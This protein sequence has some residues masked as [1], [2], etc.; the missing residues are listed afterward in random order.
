MG[1]ARSRPRFLAEIVRSCEQV[2]VGDPARP[3]SRARAAGANAFKLD[4]FAEPSAAEG[5][6]VLARERARCSRA[7]KSSS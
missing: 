3:A 4:R 7:T 1:D 5:P 6:L 2:M